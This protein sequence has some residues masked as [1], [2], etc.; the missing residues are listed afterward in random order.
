MPIALQ[1]SFRGFS[2]WALD[3]SGPDGRRIVKHASFG[4][5]GVETEDTGS[6]GRHDQISA[7]FTLSEFKAF[8]AIVHQAKVGHFRHPGGLGS[9]RAR[10]NMGQR[11]PNPEDVET[12]LVDLEFIEDTTQPPAS[13]YDDETPTSKKN[14]AASA[15]DDADKTMS[16]TPGDELTESLYATFTAARTDFDAQVDAYDAESGN[17]QDVERALGLLKS[18]GWAVVENLRAFTTYQEDACSVW[19]NIIRGLNFCHEYVEAIK[20][21]GVQWMK[22]LVIDQPQDIYSLCMEVYDDPAEGLE[23]A[24]KVMAK[25]SV[26]DPFCIE[27]NT[28]EA[29]LEFP[30]L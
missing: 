30:I 5:D 27:P 2:F 4:R 25:N 7:R 11:R 13:P 6:D 23:Q 22:V 8:R 20:Q 29:V 21:Q 24:D 17:W 19:D 3:W 14:Q 15:F 16:G 9:W 10:V 28:P 12:V 26:L 1:A 18:T